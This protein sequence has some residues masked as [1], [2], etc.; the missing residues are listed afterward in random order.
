MTRTDLISNYNSLQTSFRR[1]FARGLT[2]NA[3]YTWSHSLDEGGIAFGTAAQDDHNPRDA[4]GNADYD[5]RHLL[6]FD[7]TY[8]IPA[9][10]KALPFLFNGWR[11]NGLTQ[12][13]SG[14]SANVTC[15][16][17]SM[18]IGSASSRPDLVPGVPL[19]PANVDIPNAQ[20]N[21]LALKNPGARDLGKR[22]PQYLEGA[23]G[24]QLGFFAVQD[25]SCAGR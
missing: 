2:F 15:G 7:Y 5:A 6:E 11:I 19:R 1:R 9:P 8:E 20:F 22:G 18:L 17:D 14:L 3:N 10:T 12:M 23:G 24:L 4:Y 16:C 25:L 21:I 13:R